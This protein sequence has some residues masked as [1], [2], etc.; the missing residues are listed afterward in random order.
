MH[1]PATAL[2]AL[3][4]LAA[5]AQPDS[6][7]AS[8]TDAESPAPVEEAGPVPDVEPADQEAILQTGLLGE[9][10][11][12]ER[13]G[14]DD[15]TLEIEEPSR[16]TVNF[17]VDGVAV[18]ADCNRGRGSYDLDGSSLTFA[19]FALTRRACPPDSHADGFVR[20]LGDVRSWVIEDGHLF[21]SLRA[22][23]GILEFRPG[24]GPA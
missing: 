19:P 1:R 24:E 17:M 22:D 13:Q 20:D 3:V 12:V 15:T 5:C 10:Q 23:G 6:D 14:M 7:G 11:W 18:R 2:L 4:A 9:W 21:L 16:Y 8:E